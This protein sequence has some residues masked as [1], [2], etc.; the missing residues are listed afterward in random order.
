[1]F[2]TAEEVNDHKPGFRIQHTKLE[3][4]GFVNPADLQAQIKQA[5]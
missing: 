1:M 3:L 5:Q 2:Y 4:Q